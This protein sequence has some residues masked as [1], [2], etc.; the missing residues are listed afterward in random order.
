[1]ALPI[2]F[3]GSAAATGL[4]AHAINKGSLDVA[5]TKEGAADL[6]Y[7]VPAASGVAGIGAG[8]IS[9][10]LLFEKGFGGPFSSTKL[11]AGLGVGL[12]GGTIS[13]AVAS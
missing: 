13:G 12:L 2:G 3:L 4:V 6:L 5:S 7:G 1:M 10:G 11:V 9:F 8:V